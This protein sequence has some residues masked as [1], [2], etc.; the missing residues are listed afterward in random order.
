MPNP[1]ILIKPIPSQVVNEGAAFGPFNLTDFIQSPDAESG[2]LRFQAELANG[3]ALMTGLIC[4][5]NGIVS[6]IPAKGTEGEYQIKITAQ[7]DAE[8]SLQTEFNLS[9]KSRAAFATDED[10]TKLKA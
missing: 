3:N 4:T 6:G 8:A 1:P 7:N 10:F 5:S 9:I 2:V